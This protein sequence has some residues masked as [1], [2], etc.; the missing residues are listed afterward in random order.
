MGITIDLM[1]LLTRFV[2]DTGVSGK[3][4]TFGL[5]RVDAQY[6]DLVRLFEQENF[7]YRKPD[8]GQIK[9]VCFKE[10]ENFG[11]TIHQ[12]IAFYM[13]GFDEIHSLD[14]YTDEGATFQADLNNPVDT[15]RW[16]QY[17]LV[18]DGGTMEHC[19]NVKEVLFN[20]IRLVK[21]GGYMI[22]N[23]PV[24]GWVNHGFFQ[25]S[26]TLYFDFYAI[27]GFSDFNMKLILENRYIDY[28]P[29]YTYNDF[30]GEPGMIM[31]TARKQNVVDEIKIPIQ[32][33]Y[34]EHFE[35]TDVSDPNGTRASLFNKLKTMI[36]SRRLMH[37]L[38]AV[39]KY[40]K[41]KQNA[42]PLEKVR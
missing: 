17:D 19:F 5:Q 8:P 7:P 20:S 25:F 22:H 31:F 37:K 2:K 28:N 11:H 14:Y 1:R 6:E 24:S 35:S 27:N 23:N 39:R 13:L 18:L 36:P 38:M 16:G 21:E 29:H 15:A 4:L 9:T 42:H 10:F 34:R 26:P 32:C 3:V 12:D 40:I 30:L 33:Y 41:M